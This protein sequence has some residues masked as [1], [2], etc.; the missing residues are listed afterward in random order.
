M[1]HSII[2][3][4]HNQLFEF[5]VIRI[6]FALRVGF[7]WGGI[8]FL[9]SYRESF[10]WSI[11]LDHPDLAYLGATFLCATGSASVKEATGET[12]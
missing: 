3:L 12:T 4:E 10:V 2:A 6:R 7:F 8:E 1:E 5:S 9:I 11:F